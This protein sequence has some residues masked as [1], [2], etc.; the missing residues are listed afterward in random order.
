MNS[1]GDGVE[2]AFKDSDKVMTVSFHHY[3][4]DFFPGTGQKIAGEVGTRCA[5]NVP[6]KTGASDALYSILF[7]EVLDAV[8]LRF[9]PSAV[10]LQCGA[11]SLSGDE[12][13]SAAQYNLSSKGHAKCVQMVRDLKLPLVVL[14]GGGYTPENV[15][16]CWANETAVLCDASIADE[17]P[18]TTYHA[19]FLGTSVSVA[20]DQQ[21]K[22]YNLNVRKDYR[23]GKE[24]VSYLT[25][26]RRG[27][28]DALNESHSET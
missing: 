8:N 2:E 26:L 17:I 10:V 27:I 16:K 3:D 25:Y 18:P 6:L 22:D 28:H 14:G 5:I 1:H 12:L 19:R 24:K 13:G 15:A 20:A 4:G 23:W 11:D 9:H 7:K 21:L